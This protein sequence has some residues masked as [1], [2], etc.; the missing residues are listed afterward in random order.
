[1]PLPAPRT[2]ADG[3]SEV[4]KPTVDDLN[5]DW[6]DSFDF[7]LGYSRPMAL[8]HH[9]S[10]SVTIPLS[11]TLVAIPFNVEVLKRGGMVHS[12]VTNNTR[13]QVPYTGQYTGY[14]YAGWGTT[15]TASKVSPRLR[16]NG[17]TTI[18]RPG[19]FTSVTTTGSETHGTFTVDLAANDYVEMVVTTTGVATTSNTGGTNRCK[20]AM[21]YVG[22]YV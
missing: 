7:L 8:L 19:D 12:T 1:M 6:R 2:W 11:P 20:M 18:A 9:T 10:G 17:T 3:E 4:N 16:K 14:L 22:D 13:L 5:L 21:W 15:T